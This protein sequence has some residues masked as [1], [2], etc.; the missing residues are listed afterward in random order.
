MDLSIS[1]LN[2]NTSDLLVHCLKSVVAHSTDLD[3]ELTVIDNGST[4]ADVREIAKGF[5]NFRWIFNRDNRGGQALDKAWDHFR[6]R[7]FLFLSPDAHIQTECLQE[8]VRFLDSHPEAGGV[9]GQLLNP[10]GSLQHYYRRLPT[11]GISFFCWT[12]LGQ[13]VDTELLKSRFTHYYRYEGLRVDS[14]VEIEQPAA[15]AFLVRRELVRDK[16][17][18][19]ISPKFPFYFHDVDLCKRIYIAGYRIFVLPT[20]RVIHRLGSSFAKRD[21]GWKLGE[22]H[23][24]MLRYLFRHHIVWACVFYTF[25]VCE[26]LFSLGLNYTRRVLT[27]NNKSLAER[28]AEGHQILSRIVMFLR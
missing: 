21:E 24:S 27:S 4:D 22:N 1:V 26:T 23:A 3:Y 17:G 11:A 20:A 7:Y 13:R 18:F 25:L 12:R 10:D 15:P 8:M 14:L 19:I 9:C 16:S 2:W 28:I 5:P 6:G